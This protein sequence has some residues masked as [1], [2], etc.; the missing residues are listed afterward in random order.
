MLQHGIE[1][2]KYEIIESN[3]NDEDLNDREKY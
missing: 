2:Y 1:H 3:I